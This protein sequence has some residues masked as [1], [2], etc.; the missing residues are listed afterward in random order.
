M[1]GVLA[2]AK[3]AASLKPMLMVLT[4]YAT[5]KCNTH[6]DWFRL[7]VIPFWM[8]IVLSVVHQKVG[9]LSGDGQGQQQQLQLWWPQLGGEG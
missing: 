6:P 3:A 5:G 8:Q 4:Q 9:F 7:S 1:K 2:M